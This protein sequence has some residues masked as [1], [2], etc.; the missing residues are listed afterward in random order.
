MRW[1][2]L[3]NA[4]HVGAFSVLPRVV[5]AKQVRTSRG[6]FP[7]AFFPAGPGTWCLVSGVR[8]LGPGTW[9]LVSGV[10]SPVSGPR[11]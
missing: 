2:F 9:G 3:R 11:P 7:P 5:R 8:C 10:R 4:W 1:L 6:P